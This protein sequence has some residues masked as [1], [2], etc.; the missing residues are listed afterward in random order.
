MVI[1]NVFTPIPSEVIMPLAGFMTLQNEL[2]FVG[3]VIAGAAGSVIGNLALY[4]VGKKIG[5]ERLK[6]WADRHRPWLMLSSDD[7]ERAK[8]WF[9]RHGAGAV[10]LCRLVPGVRSLI[11]IP[12]GIAT[13]NPMLFLLLSS[14]GNGIWSGV[15]AYLGRTLGKNHEIVSTY[16]GPVSYIVFASLVIWYIVYTVRHSRNRSM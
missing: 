15:L 10:L 5:G 2:S 4:Y 11:S 9:H 7:I 14:C 16:L 8:A 12:A 3:V 13:M 1:E 6:R